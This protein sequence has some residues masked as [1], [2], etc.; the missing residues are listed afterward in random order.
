[1]SSA[2][3]SRSN[4]RSERTRSA[5]ARTAV[6][7][8]TP[9]W[10]LAVLALALDVGL[11]AYGLQIG[12]AEANPV[13]R[14]LIDAVGFVGALAVLKGGAVAVGVAAWRCVPR[15]YRIVIP[16]GLALPWLVATAINAVTIVRVT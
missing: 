12:L 3:A 8:E 4:S 6:A 5:L 13:A 7:L 2:D 10:A 9:A 16:S 11:T 14:R 15:P 1:M